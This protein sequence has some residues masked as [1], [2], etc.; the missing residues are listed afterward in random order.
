MSLNVVLEQVVAKQA[1]HEAAVNQAKKIGKELES[2]ESMAAELLGATGMDRVVCAGKSWR[3][4]ESIYVSVPKINR[5]EVM[6]A[7][8]A[9]GIADELTTVNTTTLKAWLLERRGGEAGEQSIAD[10]TAFV[11]LI[12]EYREVRLRCRTS[13]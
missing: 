1:E 4:E 2:L 11:G 7:A 5:E 10:G 13:V 12:S 6:K 3:L 8:I 9:E